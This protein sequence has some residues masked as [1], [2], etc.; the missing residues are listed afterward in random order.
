MQVSRNGFSLPVPVGVG[1]GRDLFAGLRQILAG[2]W[3]LPFH[4]TG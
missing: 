2:Y 1:L 3:W 4:R